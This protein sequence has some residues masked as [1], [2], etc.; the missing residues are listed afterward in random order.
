MLLL[1]HDS[2]CTEYQPYNPYILLAL[3]LMI[4]P[5]PKISINQSYLEG[6]LG[7]LDTHNVLNVTIPQNMCDEANDH[8]LECDKVYDL[9][10][11]PQDK[12]DNLHEKH[13]LHTENM[14]QNINL[15]ELFSMII[16]QN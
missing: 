1:P 15:Y 10:E 8:S 6:I 16:I 3:V 14:T 12:L 11:Y 2:L 5:Y 13:F 7:K 9:C 4:L